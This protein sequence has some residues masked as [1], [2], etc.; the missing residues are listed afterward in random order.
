MVSMRGASA[1]A[2]ADAARPSS[3]ARVST[4]GADAA[5]VG[6]ELF[7]RSRCSSRQR[8]LG[9]AAVATDVH[10]RGEATRGAGPT[11]SSSDRSTRLALRVWWTWRSA[12]AGRPSRRPRRRAGAPRRRWPSVT[13]GGLGR[14]A[15][16]GRALP[17]RPG[18]PAQPRPARRAVGPRP[19]P[20]ETRPR[21]STACS[22]GKALAGHRHAGQAVAR[23]HLPD[24][25]GR[26]ATYQKIA[27]EVHGQR[28]RH[29]A[30][31]RRASRTPSGPASRSPCR[32]QYG[33]DVHLN[34]VV[35]PSVIGGIRRGDRRRRHRRHRAS[36]GST[37]HDAARRLTTLVRPPSS[38]TSASRRE[39]RN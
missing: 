15:A 30:V 39:K 6:D 28:R 13:L 31:A 18:G 12:S 27:A 25:R 38:T 1:E 14:R 37:T 9:C 11:R 33:R 29:R 16:R 26:L 34:V 36:A 22:T 2:L 23:G 5:T 10:C 21:S 24:R 20:S 4:G 8:G 32:A 17:A 19:A 7:D 35:D 3:T